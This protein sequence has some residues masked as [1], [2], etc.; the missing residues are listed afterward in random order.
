MR[1][2]Q[3]FGNLG[4]RK[5]APHIVK[6]SVIIPTLNEADNLPLVLPY[7][8]LDMIHEVILVDG[9]SI[10]RTIEVAKRLMPSIRVIIEPRRGKGLA[11]RKGYEAASGDILIVLDA[12]GSNDPWE[13]PRFVRALLEGADFA[14]GSRFADQ[15][16][17]TDMPRIRVL[18]NSAFVI[19]VNLFFG[20]KFSDLC[21]GYHAFWRYC[22][23]LINLSDVDGFEIDT[24]IY[25]RAVRER[26]RIIDVP[27]FEGY[28]FHG[29]GKLKTIPDGFRVL[30]TIFHEWLA[31]LNTPKKQPYP[32]F[33][34]SMPVEATRPLLFFNISNSLKMVLNLRNML[35]SILQT[36]ID[37]VG[38]V[39]GSI[40]VVDE[41]CNEIYGCI[42]YQGEIYSPSHSV[43]REIIEQGLAGWVMRQQEPALVEN[44]REDQRWLYRSWEEKQGAER[45]AMGIP[46]VVLDRIVGALTLVSPKTGSFTEADLNRVAGVAL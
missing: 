42:F 38:A 12:D 6:V 39:S 25:L 33:R 23:D 30:R 20:C 1:Q 44:T 16:G 15:G 28:R 3:M 24:A 40:F 41:T 19:L 31:Y 35:P 10:D 18:G 22:L 9:G 14:K 46:L 21:Y 17:T 2:F 45:S 4:E 37:S 29:E 34:R 36:S 13:I 5:N 26:L 27:S 11:L 32:G 8:P 43:L 7:I